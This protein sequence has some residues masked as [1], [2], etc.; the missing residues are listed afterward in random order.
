MRAAQLSL[1]G[2][3]VAERL[4]DDAAAFNLTGVG[5]EL[6]KDKKAL[7]ADGAANAG[8]ELWVVGDEMHGGPAFMTRCR[9]GPTPIT[10]IF[11]DGLRMARTARI[12]KT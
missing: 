3:L 10:P 8:R 2:M 12:L 6:F 9:K 7:A 11:G 1:R 5:G 4:L